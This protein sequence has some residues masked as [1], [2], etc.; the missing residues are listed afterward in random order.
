M[1]KKGTKKK[2]KEA[3]KKD[4]TDIPPEI[5]HEKVA[6]DPNWKDPYTYDFLWEEV[7]NILKKVNPYKTAT[8]EFHVKPI[9]LEKV[10]RQYKW[11]NFKDF[12]DC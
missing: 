10:G 8:K 2:E 4:E 1:G 12:C 5:N 9:S 6:L 3:K 7:Y 11:T